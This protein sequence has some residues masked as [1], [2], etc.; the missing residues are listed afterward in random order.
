MGRGAVGGGGGG[1]PAGNGG[2][3]P[4]SSSTGLSCLSFELRGGNLDREADLEGGVGVGVST[5]AIGSGAGWTGGTDR[6]LSGGGGGTLSGG[7]A[8]TF[9]GSTSAP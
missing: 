2:G 5:E 1:R 6:R 3:G 4:G 9:T 7:G 8:G